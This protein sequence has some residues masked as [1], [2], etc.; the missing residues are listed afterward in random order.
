MNEEINLKA[1]VLEKLQKLYFHD[2]SFRAVELNFSEVRA[3]S[4][5]L[6]IDYYDWEGN[7]IRRRQISTAQREWKSLIIDFGYVAVFEYSAP[8][9]L[10]SAREIDAVEFGH[11]L[12]EL[13]T[14]EQALLKQF[15]GYHSP[16]FDGKSEPISIKFITQNW[17]E[18]SPGYL[19]IVGSDVKISWGNFVPL[20][21]Q[22]YIPIKR[23]E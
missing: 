16:L 22:V 4:C 21:G 7:E 12:E 20:V 19:L 13:R 15:S 17:D 2:S 1:T 14:K 10:N 11:R 6:Q 18:N 9:L 3:R 23:D 8:D 5:R